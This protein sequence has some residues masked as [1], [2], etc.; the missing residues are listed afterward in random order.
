M[1]IV[2]TASDVTMEIARRHLKSPLPRNLNAS[3]RYEG[4]MTSCV[5]GEVSRCQN[6]GDLI[7]AVG[8]MRQSF[9]SFE[10]AFIVVTPEGSVRTFTRQAD[11]S[12]FRFLEIMTDRQA[13][14]WPA[15]WTGGNRSTSDPT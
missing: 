1:G 7:S 9:G 4:S 6:L 8:R 12:F 15:P 13:S 2:P 14:G 11:E 5:Q 10:P 3:L